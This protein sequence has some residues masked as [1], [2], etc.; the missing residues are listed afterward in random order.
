MLKQSWEKTNVSS[1]E[2][3]H[4][5]DNKPLYEHRFLHVLKYHAPGLAP[6]RDDSGA[7]HIDVQGNAAYAHRFTETFGF[8]EHLAA[9]N[10]NHQ[11]FHITPTGQS[12]YTSRFRWCGNFQEGCCVVK[13]DEGFYTHI[14]RKGRYLY[15][16][17]YPYVGDFKEGIAVIC[18]E[19]GL[20]THI[21][22][23][24]IPLYQQYF[25]DLDIFHKGYA[26]AKDERGWHHINKAGKALYSHRYAQ[27]E[28]FYN[29]IA[30]VETMDGELLT[31][32][33]Q[34]N[35]LTVIR[36][37]LSQPWQQLSNEMVGFWRTEIIATAVKLKIFDALP[38]STAQ[39]ANTMKI[40]EKHLHRLL[41]A[42]WE[43]DLISYSASIWQ[44]T[45]KGKWLVTEQQGAFLSSAAIM[46]SDVN[47]LDWKALPSYIQ[48]GYNDYHPLFKAKASGTTLKH[49]H[50][51]IDGYAAQD[52]AAINT[53]VDWQK[54]H[55]LIAVGRSSVFILTKLLTTFPHLQ[56]LLL[57]E[58]YVLKDIDSHITVSFDK[59]QHDI[60]TPWPHTADAI[61]LPKVVHYWPESQAQNIL[62]QAANALTPHGKIYLFEL[63][64][65]EETA[66]GSLLDLNMLVES[67]GELRCLSQWQTLLASTGLTIE[68]NISIHA[69]LNL[70][71]V[72][73]QS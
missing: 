10:Q 2:T 50:R 69:Y 41:R 39:L 30:R 44:L 8:Y 70:L 48:S 22:K 65:A 61:L 60:L 40:P 29:G 12:L 28:P 56:G 13:N 32:N 49:Y 58:A 71:V 14:D 51:A 37:A 36:K 17:V 66:Q 9:V 25:L 64:L 27:I 52:F 5:V 11:W 23:Y 7:F 45:N 38:G 42:L 57:D 4:L 54:H 67:G 53:L 21:D 62:M 35:T 3:F 47:S 31:I 59:I 43:L 55:Q 26:R 20:H 24:G 68:A 18:N 73:K 1:C 72:T 15:K 63:I 33:T 46:W 34:G 16:K 19:H 6:V